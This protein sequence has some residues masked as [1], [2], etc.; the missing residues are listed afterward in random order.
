MKETKCQRERK[1]RGRER[2]VEKEGQ[3]EGSSLWGNCTLQYI[4]VAGPVYQ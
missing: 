1:E 4:T 2:E 3:W